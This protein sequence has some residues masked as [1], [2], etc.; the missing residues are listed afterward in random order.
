MVVSRLPI[1][2]GMDYPN[3]PRHGV[4]GGWQGSFRKTHHR[5]WVCH[6][7]M[8]VLLSTGE[9]VETHKPDRFLSSG[10]VRGN[11]RKPECS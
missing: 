10:F 7:E 2:Q 3:R 9:A 1:T 8:R 11:P 4:T 6:Q 5:L